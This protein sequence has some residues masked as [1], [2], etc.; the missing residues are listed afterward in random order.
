MRFYAVLHRVDEIIEDTF[1]VNPSSYTKREQLLCDC[2]DK[3]VV[4]NTMIT[5]YTNLFKKSKEARYD[6][7]KYKI[8]NHQLVLSD[9]KK[10]LEMFILNANMK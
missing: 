9:T 7:L 6:F 3:G 4:D 2:R 8:N 5:A 1:H 10:W